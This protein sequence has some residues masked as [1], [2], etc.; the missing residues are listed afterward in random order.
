VWAR[1]QKRTVSTTKR[2]SER[3]EGKR[4]NLSGKGKKKGEGREKK[5]GEGKKKLLFFPL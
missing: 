3:R 4:K 1:A 2:R 5:K